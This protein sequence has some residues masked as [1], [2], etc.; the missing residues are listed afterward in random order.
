MKKYT[1]YIISFILCLCVVST[2]SAQIIEWQK[3]YGGTGSDGAYSIKQT[4]DG[5]FVAAGYTNSNDGDVSGNHGN[6]DVWI[7][8]TDASGNLQW[9][10][11]FGGSNQDYAKSI[12]QTSDGGFIVA[13]NSA[14]HDGD[15]SGYHGI[16]DYWIIKLDT[17]GNLQWQKCFGGTSSEYAE[18]IILTSDGG[19]LIIGECSSNNGDVTGFHGYY[20]VWAVKIDSLGNLQWQKCLGGSDGDNANS[21]LQT[22]DGRYI[23]AGWTNSSNGDVTGHL[24]G[25]DAWIVVLD[26]AGNLEWQKCYGA[27][28]GA[29]I[30]SSIKQTDN[31]GYIIAGNTNAKE[32][33][34][35]NNSDYNFWI[36]K[37]DSSGN[38]LWQKCL[39][40]HGWDG[41]NSVIQS[42]DGDYLVIG[43]TESFDEDVSGNHGAGD[44]LLI[45]IDTA[46]S[47]QWQKCFGGTSTDNANVITNTTDGGFVFAGM[48]I[49]ND[50]DVSGLNGSYDFWIVKIKSANFITGH[51]FNDLNQN[52]LHEIYEPFLQNVLVKSQSTN[53]LHQ[54]FTNN[55]GYFCNLVD[56]GHFSTSVLPQ[57]FNVS[58]QQHVS[59]FDTT[60]LSD[61]VNFALVSF[62]GIHDL[63]VSFVPIIEEPPGFN[64]T[65]KIIYHNSGTEVMN[66][67]VILYNDSRINFISSAPMPDSS[68]TEYEH[69]NFTNLAPFE[70]RTIY[71]TMHIPAPPTVNVGDILIY[72]G[73][74][75][76]VIG[77]TFPS[78]NEFKLLQTVTGAIDPNDKT[79]LS[80]DT[81]PLD[82]IVS[83]AYITYLIR[84]QNTGTDT[85]FSVEV[86]D[87]LDTKLDLQS[88]ETIDASHAY[89]LML[90]EPNV[91][92]WRFE[93]ILLPDS[94][95]NEA[96][97]KGYVCF[98]IKPKTSVSVDDVIVNTA[99]IYFD[100]NYPVVT[101]TVDVVVGKPLN[102]SINHIKETDAVSIFPNPTT[103][104]ITVQFS[105]AGSFNLSLKLFNGVGK[106][107]LQ[108][109]VKHNNSSTFQ[110]D[111]QTLPS[112]IYFLELSN[113]NQKWVEK[114]VIR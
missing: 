39:G 38:M 49:S 2:T 81:L 35:Y 5:G 8:K 13:C 103:E 108:K 105:Q 114:I 16:Q 37:I 52:G 6:S 89:E 88:L 64:M 102:N 85:A 62:S 42:L 27:S 60:G 86:R 23:I 97:S 55:E 74:I 17:L 26:S 66:G 106:T 57:Y 54:K 29:E 4:F 73:E 63:N 70:S 100:F 51:V 48:T 45:K 18:D 77:D 96:G 21:V 65:Y 58:P 19:Y 25:S 33:T 14:S 93:N 83:G 107:I 46:G 113:K 11:C 90:Y 9:Q 112:G 56:T 69:W 87:T 94:S 84:F 104:K 98:R 110:L 78:D 43:S 31:G 59:V 50:G 92:E 80:K 61:T 67:K 30:I 10:K 28:L 12:K 71:C 15:V 22:D 111:L 76:P 32:I 68:V 53:T 101:N 7:I 47:L 95:T 82:N 24:G 20:D 41:A 34:G 1:I 44:A 72:S 79:V 36:F 109:E 99:N 40:G 75:L 91:L 3:C